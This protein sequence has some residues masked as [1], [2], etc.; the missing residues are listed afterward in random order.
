MFK[1]GECALTYD[2]GGDG[3]LQGYVSYDHDHKLGCD[4]P[5]FLCLMAKVQEIT[6][7]S[8]K[9]SL[10]QSSETKSRRLHTLKTLNTTPCKTLEA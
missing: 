6:A 7:S 3:D 5:L 2:E 4:C 8:G 9:N 10:L 1:I